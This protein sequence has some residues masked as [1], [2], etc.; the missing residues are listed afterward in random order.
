MNARYHARYPMRRPRRSTLVVSGLILAAAGV[1]GP[2]ALLAI[3]LD[4]GPAGFIAGL[5]MAA[6][7]VPFYMAFAL[8]VDRFEPEPWGMLA[9]SFIWGA[10]IAVFLAMIFNGINEGIFAA[11]AGPANASAMMAVLSAPFV[12]ELAKGAALLLLFFW[13]RDEF[14]NVTDGIV[15]ASMIGLGFAMTEN[16]HYYA[17]AFQQDG[18]AG[19]VTVF[20]LRGIL[21][22]FS[23]PLY[24]SMTGI[25]F[26]I[27][28]ESRRRSTKWLAPLLG[29]AA[30]MLLHAIWNLSATFGA[31]FLAT[32]VVLMVPAFV[33]VIV[34]A[35]VS[36][37][38]EAKIIRAHLE[39]V[40]AERILSAD[41]LA[42]VVS[43]RRRIAAST[44][45][46]LE[47]GF[48]KWSARR[49]FHALATELAFHSWRAS[50]EEC[51]DAHLTHAELV[52]EIRATRER[53]GLSAGTP[54]PVST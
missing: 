16:I 12:E 43:V 30:A 3:G 28:R 40:V 45:A 37:R 33:A 7:P 24:T 32:Y 53:L 39:C 18:G 51:A 29:L 11:I 14:D 35:V 15:Y 13:R 22:P 41:D 2:L 54:A 5:L 27:A 46:L 21:G 44:R 31:V 38:R 8:W 23:H 19:A 42:V 4:T 47:G 17:Q 50:R 20:F 6:V 9:I 36:L 1:A 52:E 48:G 10:S 34:I 25:G 26:G 49:R